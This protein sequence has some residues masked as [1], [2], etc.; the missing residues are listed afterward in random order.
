MAPMS[1]IVLKQQNVVYR[2]S[3]LGVH[4]G[5]VNL[6]LS[7]TGFQGTNKLLGDLISRISYSYS[8]HVEYYLGAH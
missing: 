8:F 1:A 5:I 2:A 3:V 4:V 6:T 7:G